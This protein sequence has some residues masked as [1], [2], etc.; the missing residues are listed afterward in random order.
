M[1][2]IIAYVPESMVKGQ[3]KEA[4]NAVAD[5]CAGI[6]GREKGTIPVMI[7]KTEASDGNACAGQT[8]VFYVYA[9]TK[10]GRE[11]REQAAETIFQVSQKYF[12]GMKKENHMVIFKLHEQ[13]AMGV[14]GKFEE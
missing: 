4:A 10:C 14:N 12:P 13:D 9:G 1:E 6:F 2:T 3:L 5:E 7:H 8:I 11:I